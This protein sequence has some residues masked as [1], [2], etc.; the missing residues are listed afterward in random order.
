[1]ILGDFLELG[2]DSLKLLQLTAALE[3]SPLSAVIKPA[4]LMARPT[5]GGLR[6]LVQVALS[7]SVSGSGS[8]SPPLPTSL[9]ASSPPAAPLASSPPTPPKPVGAH[10]R[11]RS[12]S[13]PHSANHRLG[14]LRVLCLHGHSSNSDISAM[15]VLH[16]QMPGVQ[17]EMLDAPW[18]MSM[19]GQHE[20]QPRTTSNLRTWGPT[21]STRRI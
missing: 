1:M 17:C 11:D 16:L 12:G 8:G 15:Q 4:E 9:P 5:L 3:Q 2:G 14:P 10:L 6:Q 13:S 20:Q 19:P 18:A 7:V 21:P